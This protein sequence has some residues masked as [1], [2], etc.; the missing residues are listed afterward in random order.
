MSY[1]QVN[2]DAEMSAVESDQPVLNEPKMDDAAAQ[3]MEFDPACDAQT[4]A[5]DATMLDDGKKEGM[6]P[7]QREMFDYKNVHKERHGY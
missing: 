5:M 4:N 3:A 2:S 6:D 1:G 7:N